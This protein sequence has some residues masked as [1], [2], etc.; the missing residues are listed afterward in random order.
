MSRRKIDLTG[1]RFGRLVVLGEDP[2]SSA[3]VICRCDCGT[4]KSVRKSSLRSH[5]TQ[6]C[7]CLAREAQHR[8]G[9]LAS[10]RNFNAH[11]EMMRKYHTQF[12]IIE[13]GVP[14]KNNKS[15]RVGVWFNPRRQCYE[16]Y[17]TLNRKKKHLGS[18]SNIAAAI[19]AREEA[20][21]LYYAPLIALKNAEIH[22]TN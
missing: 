6:S 4:Q 17:I 12:A 10:Q 3:H 18:F 8:S 11:Y 22:N 9:V 14:P 15:G 5:S 21:E 13:K 2:H 1:M 19:Q 16:A 7:G 20:E